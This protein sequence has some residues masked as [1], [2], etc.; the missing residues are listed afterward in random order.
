M[1]AQ[2]YLQRFFIMHKVIED[3][4]DEI[5]G[6]Q[7]MSRQLTPII[8]GI[9]TGKASSVSLIEKSIVDIHA[10]TEEL[11]NDLVHALAARNEIADIIATVENTDERC[12]LEMRYLGLCSWKTIARRFNFS[13]EWVFKLH[14]RAL[15]NL[16]IK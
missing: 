9:P 12:L 14:S 7:A 2:K 4:I 5:V 8:K 16:S 13:L 15:K 3:K 10:K 6:L 1:T 11:A